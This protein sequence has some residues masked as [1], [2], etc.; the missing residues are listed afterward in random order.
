MIK[1]N[2]AAQEMLEAHRER[3]QLP[4]ALKNARELGGIELKD[5]RHV[6]R[7]LLLDG[8]RR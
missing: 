6:R 1:M 5:G 2:F 4:L 7:G 8:L 3:T